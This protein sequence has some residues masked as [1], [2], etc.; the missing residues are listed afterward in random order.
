MET[1]IIQAE[2][3]VEVRSSFPTETTEEVS[4]GCRRVTYAV[5]LYNL[6]LHRLPLSDIRAS[7]FLKRREV[8]NV[9]PNANQNILV[10][11]NQIKHD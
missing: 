4:G 2:V 10:E 9:W 8:L 6:L 5:L 3:S 11:F 7:T 1:C